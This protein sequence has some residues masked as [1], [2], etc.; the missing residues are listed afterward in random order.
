[1]DI[2]IFESKLNYGFKKKVGPLP[3]SLNFR[4][5]I[6]VNLCGLLFTL[7]LPYGS[8]LVNTI[9]T[10]VLTSCLWILDNS[11]IQYL[12]YASHSLF[13]LCCQKGMD[14]S[15]SVDH[16]LDCKS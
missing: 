4:V 13:T 5:K 2:H 11:C 9:Y 3:I 15:L 8:V 6:S 14:S 1:M 10:Y 16:T 12:A 7:G